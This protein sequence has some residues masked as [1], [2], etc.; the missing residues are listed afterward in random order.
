MYI[1]KNKIITDLKTSP[2]EFVYKGTNTF[3]NG[4]YWKSYDGKFY[5]GKNPNETPTQEIEARV[6]VQDYNN[7][8]SPPLQSSI[9]YTDSVEPFV[10][11]ENNTY[12]EE[13][14]IN[15]SVLKNIN[16]NRLE[17][18]NIPSQYY[19]TPTINDYNLGAFSRYFV[20]KSNE[21]I[22]TEVNKDTY[23]S[24]N[25][26]STDWAWELYIP[27]TILWTLTGERDNVFI[28]N[29][30]ITQLTEQ[31]LKKR[32]LQEFLKQNYL[33]FYQTNEQNIS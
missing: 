28:T 15:Y 7:L 17:T 6:N 33:K 31:R 4:S 18:K 14:V 27:F 30:N 29:R 8:T 12:N 25:S 22:Y 20:V 23:D 9:L 3:Y 1:P 11:S 10:G 19:P 24:I 16:L 13:L 26:Q 21:N 2:N 32:G 5:T